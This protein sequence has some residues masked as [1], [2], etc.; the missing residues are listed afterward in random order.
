MVTLIKK[1][2]FMPRTG[3]NKMVGLQGPSIAV[4]KSVQGAVL[5]H[6]SESQL[7]TK[8]PLPSLKGFRRISMM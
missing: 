1:L 6:V 5:S 4:E 3:I 7:Q 2:L 8:V